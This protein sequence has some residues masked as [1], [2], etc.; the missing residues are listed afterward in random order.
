M[1]SSGITFLFILM[2]IPNLYIIVV[3]AQLGSGKYGDALRVLAGGGRAANQIE[4]TTRYGSASVPTS[5]AG[6]AATSTVGTTEPASSADLLQKERGVQGSG[7]PNN[8][9][10]IAAPDG[11]S[12]LDTLDK[13]QHWEPKTQLTNL[14]YSAEDIA[15]GFLDLWINI[16]KFAKS[17]TPYKYQFYLYIKALAKTKLQ[18]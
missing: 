11:S 14:Q 4:Y 3:H 12:A 5:I 6:P 17:K 7:V 2:W 13:N 8:S 10:D 15:T 18:I 16:D 9:G 1:V